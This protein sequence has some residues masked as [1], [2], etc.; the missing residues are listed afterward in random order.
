MD[1]EVKI[2]YNLRYIT[3]CKKISRCFY[4]VQEKK[5]LVY[6]T[7]F[8]WNLLSLYYSYSAVCSFVAKFLQ[9]VKLQ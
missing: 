9:D 3:P 4:N 2:N 8:E 6:K 1:Q 7:I 5:N